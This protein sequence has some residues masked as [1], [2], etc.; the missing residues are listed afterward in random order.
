M[1]ACLR[2]PRSIADPLTLD[3]QLVVPRIGQGMS[4]TN[5]LLHVKRLQSL[6]TPQWGKNHPDWE[7][8]RRWDSTSETTPIPP[9]G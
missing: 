4:N 5:Q 6:R 2:H 3:L 1:K 7:G 9:Y 8:S